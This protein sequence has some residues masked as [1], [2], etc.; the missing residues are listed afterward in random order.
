MLQPR[1][2]GTLDVQ[3][4]PIAFLR[5][6]GLN[7]KTTVSSM[8]RA[9]RIPENLVSSD[10]LPFSSMGNF[11]V[12]S[13][14]LVTVLGI[15]LQSSRVVVTNRALGRPGAF[16]PQPLFFRYAIGRGKYAVYLAPEVDVLSS[17]YQDF[18]TRLSEYDIIPE[19]QW[20]YMTAIETAAYASMSLILRG[21]GDATIGWQISNFRPAVLDRGSQ[22]YGRCF[23]ADLYMSERNS[24]GNTYV[25][26]YN[27]VDLAT[28][29][30][31]VRQ[32]VANANPVWEVI[33][34][35]VS[36]GEQSVR[37]KMNDKLTD[38][39]D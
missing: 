16:K 19:S 8:D 4:V 10:S 21:Q 12:H 14:Y 37:A 1:V 34:A 33:E 27:G 36:G 26:A 11:E 9:H 23:N 13:D 20:K 2:T 28:N 24:N 32:E 29:L 7:A 6:P 25:L 3:S 17:D 39:L 5:G 15:G 38:I 30:Q 18:I 31:V 35:N 22:L